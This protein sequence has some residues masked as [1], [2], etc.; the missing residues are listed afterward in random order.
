MSTRFIDLRYSLKALLIAAFLAGCSAPMPVPPKPAPSVKA[1]PAV[2]PATPAPP[3]AETAPAKNEVNPELTHQFAQA[4]VAMQAGEDE[5]AMALFTD[6]AKQNPQLASPHTNL[7]ILFYKEGK[8]TEAEAA[9]KEAL[10]RDD[11]EYV[12]ANYLGMI[13]RKLGRF[14]EAQAD[15]ERA[16]AIKPDYAYAHLN[17]AILYDLYI[18]NLTKALDHYQ[19]YQKLT[20]DDD[21]QLAGWLADLQQRMQAAGGTSKP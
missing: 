1:P 5:K 7:G 12:A 13:D 16:L 9:F 11:K 4:I 8:L 20:G 10:Q 17:M 3:A 18:G 2:E 19:Q 15:Y 21:K 14:T 6:I